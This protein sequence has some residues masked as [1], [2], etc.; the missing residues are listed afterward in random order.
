MA[1]K[2]IGLKVLIEA[3]V[4]TVLNPDFEVVAG[5]RDA[6]INMAG[7]TID[8]SSK[9]GDG[10]KTA[11][12]GLLGWDADLDGIIVDTNAGLAAIEAAYNARTAV[13]V[14]MAFPDGSHKSG[15]ALITSMPTKVPMG[16]E[17][18]YSVKMQGNGPLITDTGVITAPS[19]T[20]PTSNETG[21]GL[22]DAATTAAFAAT[23]GTDTHSATRWQITN[24][25]DTA[26]AAPVIDTTTTVDL[27][28]LPIA[29]GVLDSGT[30]YLIRVKHKGV[31]YGWSLWS[32]VHGF[33]TV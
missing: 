31:K 27:I 21:V 17:A 3:N 12:V 28:S 5:Q 26:F 18:T 29:A 15:E 32:A 30:D 4:G 13:K 24:D 16:G 25:T 6:S 1:N 7:D 8:T 10:W 20:S 2:V 19:I 22:E 11:A 23:G 9:D 33:A 14:R